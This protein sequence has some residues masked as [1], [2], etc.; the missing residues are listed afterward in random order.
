MPSL[1][2]S[3]GRREQRKWY[4]RAHLSREFD[5]WT[6]A[7]VGGAFGCVAK[8]LIEDAGWL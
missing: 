7:A 8:N 3:I 2:C 4:F 6:K 1:F 5:C